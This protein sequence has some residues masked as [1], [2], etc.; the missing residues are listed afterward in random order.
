MHRQHV[1]S[2]RYTPDTIGI[3]HF[4]HSGTKTCTSAQ[5]TSV[6]RVCSQVTACFTSASVG[7]SLPVRCFLRGPKRCKSLG[8]RAKLQG[9]SPTACQPQRRTHSSVSSD[10]SKNN[11]VTRQ[12]RGFDV[13]CSGILNLVARWTVHLNVNGDCMCT[14]CPVSVEVV[15]TVSLPKVVTLI[16]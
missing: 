3:K 6:Q 8:A 15:T 9:G 11:S 2:R 4:S 16:V 12:T 13:F 1:C 7:R 10:P 14:T 5:K